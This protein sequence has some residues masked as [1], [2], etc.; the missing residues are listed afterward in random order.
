MDR[1]LPGSSVHRIFQASILEWVAISSSRGS[2][3]PRD[4][5]CVCCVSSTADGFF[6]HWAIEEAQSTYCK[7][8]LIVCLLVCL[9]FNNNIWN[10][11]L[12]P[13]ECKLLKQTKCPTDLNNCI[14]FIHWDAVQ[15]L[16]LLLKIITAMER[17]HSI[18]NGEK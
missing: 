15:S 13:L 17:C 9:L 14:T 11:C 10:I 2:S 5:T 12:L 7:I 8:I 3:W 6:T 16:K 1:N 4:W 18:L